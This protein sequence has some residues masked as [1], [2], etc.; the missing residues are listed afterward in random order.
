MET[1]KKNPQR[2]RA[3]YSKKF[4][5]EAVRLLQLGQKPATEVALELVVR[6]NQLYK[7]AEA[8][9]RKD[10][11]EAV[12]FNGPRG[13]SAQRTCSSLQ[14]HRDASRPSNG[15]VHRH[16]ARQTLHGMRLD[17]GTGFQCTHLYTKHTTKADRAT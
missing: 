8:L 2:V 12:A 16:D 15:H 4:K 7:W 14:P 13:S 9:S 10:G 11:D 6:R 5:L 3:R 17:Q 1:P